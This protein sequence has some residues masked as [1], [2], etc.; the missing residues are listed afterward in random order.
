VLLFCLVSFPS[1]LA[2]PLLYELCINIYAL[3]VIHLIIT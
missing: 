3:F 1:F 2:F